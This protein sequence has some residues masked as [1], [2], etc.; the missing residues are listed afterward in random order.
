MRWRTSPPAPAAC[1]GPSAF[2]DSHVIL[3]VLAGAGLVVPT[4]TLI[5]IALGVR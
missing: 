1:A 3:C 4:I 5:T 2:S